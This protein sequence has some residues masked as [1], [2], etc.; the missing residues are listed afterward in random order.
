MLDEP[1]NHLDLG[2]IEWLEGFLAQS[3]TTL[4]M[5]THDRFFLEVVCDTI[6]ELDSFTTAQ[7]PGQLELVSWR[8]KTRAICQ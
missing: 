6:F 3:K 2:M 4:L 7:V 1:T 5:V 8:R